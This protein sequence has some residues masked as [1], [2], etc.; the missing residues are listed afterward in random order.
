MK[1]NS[2]ESN[3]I[4][5]NLSFNRYGNKYSVLINRAKDK[6]QNSI[7]NYYNVNSTE[8]RWLI[9]TLNSNFFKEYFSTNAIKYSIESK[10][11]DLGDR[12]CFFINLY[13]NSNNESETLSNSSLLLLTNNSGNYAIPIVVK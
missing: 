10:K 4:N 5:E 1:Y 7:P 3:S 8:V 11:L 6:R 9:N 2:I 12:K 13:Y